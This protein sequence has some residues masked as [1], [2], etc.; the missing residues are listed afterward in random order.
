M[1]VPA[2]RFVFLLLILSLFAPG[3]PAFSH[4]AQPAPFAPFQPPP[5]Q[6]IQSDDGPFDKIAQWFRDLGADIKQAFSRWKTVDIGGAVARGI[7]NMFSG[8]SNLGKSI[9]KQLERSVPGQ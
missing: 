9:Q 4:P 8:V 2:Y 6:G 7:E 3:F 5:S 1:M